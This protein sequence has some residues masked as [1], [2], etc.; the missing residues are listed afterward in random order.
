MSG[1]AFVGGFVGGGVIAGVGVLGGVQ[2]AAAASL[3]N[4]TVL[5][6]NPNDGKNERHSKAIGRIASYASAAAG[7][8]GGIGAISTCGSVAGVSAAGISSGLAAIGGLVGGGMVGGVAVVTAAPVILAVAGGYGVYKL[9]KYA[10][11]S[12]SPALETSE[13][14]LVDHEER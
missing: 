13:M 6:D 10:I 8:A 4:N 3:V 14:V 12:D 5:K 2:G 11:G 9:A 1:L 7:T